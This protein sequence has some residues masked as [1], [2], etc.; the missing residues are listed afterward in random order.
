MPCLFRLRHLPRHRLLLSDLLILASSHS[1]VSHLVPVK[2]S[3]SHRRTDRHRHLHE[4]AV[5]SMALAR[6]HPHHLSPRPVYSAWR[7]ANL[8]RNFR[9]P[10]LHRLPLLLSNTVKA[11][12]NT[13]KL[14][15]M[16]PTSHIAQTLSDWPV[17]LR[18]MD[19]T[20]LHRR[21]RVGRCHHWQASGGLTPLHQPCI[22]AAWATPNRRR[23]R[24]VGSH[25]CINDHRA[26][27]SQVFTRLVITGST[28]K[29]RFKGVYR[30]H[31]IR[32]RSRLA[33]SLMLDELVSD[34]YEQYIGF[35]MDRISCTYGGVQ[36][37]PNLCFIFLSSMHSAWVRVCSICII[38]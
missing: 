25:H 22:M 3:H 27:V 24:R 2:W 15:S 23:H 33:N 36:P 37:S 28:V 9:T 13:S 4:P 7:L 21:P 34:G 29:A 14:W 12:I 35:R 26:L 6:S 8:A 1:L 16:V 20:L 30:V 10:P 11:T 17:V 5:L 18:N 31:C 32:N 38:R 19:R